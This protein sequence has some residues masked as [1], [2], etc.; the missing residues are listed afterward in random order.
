MHSLYPNTPLL[1]ILL[2]LSYHPRA[3]LLSLSLGVMMAEAANC[4]SLLMHFPMYF[5]LG[6]LSALEMLT[7]SIIVPVM[8]WGLLLPG[9]QTISLVACV[10]QLFLYLALGTTEFALLGAM[11]VDW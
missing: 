11:A 7:I 9:M 8:L 5:L 4:D 1:F 2:A 10:A 3:Q 6:H